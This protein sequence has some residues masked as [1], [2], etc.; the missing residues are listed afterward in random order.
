MITNHFKPLSNVPR[1]EEPSINADRRNDHHPDH[2]FGLFAFSKQALDWGAGKL[3]RGEIDTSSSEGYTFIHH[4]GTDI[5]VLIVVSSLF[6]SY[7]YVMHILCLSS[8]FLTSSVIINMQW[9]VEGVRSAR[10][11]LRRYVDGLSLRHPGM[12]SQTGSSFLHNVENRLNNREH[13]P[14]QHYD[15][16]RAR[17]VPVLATTDEAGI[18]VES[19][20]MHR[21]LDRGTSTNQRIESTDGLSWSQGTQR[22][23]SSASRPMTAYFNPSIYSNVQVHHA[24]LT[25][26]RI[27]QRRD[28]PS[29]E[30][31]ESST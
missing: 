27:E 30:L 1:E 13:Y 10:R 6:L 16:P 11:W 3:L 22:I 12:L 14:R 29:S 5:T 7:I 28:R 24:R 8:I 25:Q 9:S 15:T 18:A 2:H 23:P 4:R 21:S 31:N 17:L 19:T 26:L 20:L